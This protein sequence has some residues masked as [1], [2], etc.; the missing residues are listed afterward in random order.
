MHE[1]SCKHLLDQSTYLSCSVSFINE[2]KIVPKNTVKH[3]ESVITSSVLAPQWKLD[4]THLHWLSHDTGHHR[5][6]KEEWLFGS[7]SL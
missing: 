7:P 5:V 1:N 6:N 4:M 2:V 3:T